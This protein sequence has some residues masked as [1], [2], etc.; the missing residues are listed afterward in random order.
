MTQRPGARNGQKLRPRPHLDEVSRLDHTMDFGC[1]ATTTWPPRLSV[2]EWMAPNRGSDS[3]IAQAKDATATTG[4]SIRRLVD[5]AG[6]RPGEVARPIFP[7][8]N[9]KRSRRF[10]WTTA[11]GLAKGTKRGGRCAM[12]WQGVIEMQR[13][14]V[15]SARAFTELNAYWA[16]TCRSVRSNMPLSNSHQTEEGCHR[17]ATP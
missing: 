11:V 16:H 13:R 4:R 8:G 7:P 12:H 10:H 1:T 14:S 9:S 3:G 5:L 17:S 15:L 6:S 2:V